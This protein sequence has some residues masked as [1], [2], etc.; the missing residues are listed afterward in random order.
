MS[1]SR[2]LYLGYAFPP[3]LEALHPGA[4]PAGHG[5]ETRMIAALR[6]FFEIRS[7]GLLHVPLPPQSWGG[8]MATGIDHDLLL[9][10]GSPKFITRRRA[11]A[12]LQH[13][14][15]EWQ[16][17]GWTPD[18]VVVYNLG[19]VYNAFVRWLRRQPA[20]PRLVLLL[21]DSQQLGMP[22]PALKRLRYHFK[23]LVVPDA[24]MLKY[25]DA[26]VG[27][28]TDVESHFKALGTPFLWMPGAC[29]PARTPPAAVGERTGSPPVCFG[30]FGALAAH[31]GVG[32][33]V[34]AFRQGPIPARL[35][36][37]GYGKLSEPFARLARNNPRFQF[38]GLLPKPDDCLAFGRACD[39]LVNPRPPGY[40]NQNN[41]P[42]KLFD[43][44]L[45]G[46]A[47]LSSRISGVDRVLGPEAFYYDAIPHPASLR[48]ALE[49]IAR[50]DLHELRRRGEAIHNR[51]CTEFNWSKQAA[52]MV[53]FLG[54]IRRQSAP[55]AVT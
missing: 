47:V 55:T 37:C 34:E 43:Y 35:R 45:C 49:R 50:L 29:N 42:S 5:F 54:A 14:Y 1:H 28:S 21:L 16:A 9:A 53:D 15:R 19:P 27:L 13:R 52:R 30:Y 32:E 26:G 39:V 8:D 25:F 40:G 7:S 12:A 38:D 23:P 51:V 6:P 41:F 10:E 24:A 31:A 18:A 11:L 17:Q 46:R 4:N 3:G 44:A 36:I 20:R 22:Q 33:L 2:L 48:E